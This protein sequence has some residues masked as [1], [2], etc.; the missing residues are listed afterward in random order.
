MYD[1]PWIYAINDTTDYS[2]AVGNEGGKW[3][4]MIYKEQM[5][6]MWVKIRESLMAGKLGKEAKCST[7]MP[8]P[9]SPSS[10]IGVIIVYTNNAENE[11]D[12]MRIRSV[13][14]DLG[15]SWKIGY[16][17]DKA[18][19]NGQYNIKGKKRVSLYFC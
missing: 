1:T 11:T 4:V 17:T 3:M 8:N 13:L 19:L 12:I 2:S 15:V 5:D 18:T 9:N 10:R 6:T 14:R 16:K 7:M